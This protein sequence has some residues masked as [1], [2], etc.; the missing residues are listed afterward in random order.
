MRATAIRVCALF[1]VQ[2]RQPTGAQ[3]R[4][5]QRRSATRPFLN[6]SPRAANAQVPT[7]FAYPGSSLSLPQLPLLAPRASAAL[8]ISPPGQE[9]RGVVTLPWNTS[10]A[11]L[12]PIS[13]SGRACMCVSVRACASVGACRH[14]NIVA[15]R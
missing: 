15:L 12:R 1:S 3:D 10:V 5:R 6:F 11:H 4:A 13:S 2:S 8:R 7:T 9:S 14:R